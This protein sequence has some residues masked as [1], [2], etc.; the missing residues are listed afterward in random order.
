ML[1]SPSRELYFKYDLSRLADIDIWYCEY[2][3]VPTF[4]YQ[5][6]MWQ[7]SSTGRVDGIDADVDMNICFTNIADYD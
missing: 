3:D 7:Y 5:F 2:S 6:S 1:Y 4:Y